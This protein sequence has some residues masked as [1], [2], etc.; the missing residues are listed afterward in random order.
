MAN[1]IGRKSSPGVII[2]QFN[3]AHTKDTYDI[4]VWCI[5]FCM[6][7]TSELLAYSND[8]REGF[9]SGPCLFLIR[10]GNIRYYNACE[11][12][13]RHE[14]KIFVFTQSLSKKPT[15]DPGN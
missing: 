3:I 15:Y 8:G 10:L 2:F 9:V 5:L 11:L 1:A 14:N 7:F 6:A 13:G 12:D 4:G